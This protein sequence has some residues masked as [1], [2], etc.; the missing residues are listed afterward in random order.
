MSEFSC[1]V[2]VRSSA[3]YNYAAIAT[4]YPNA[5]YS[6]ISSTTD[7]YG[8]PWYKIYYSGSKTGYVCGYYAHT[9]TTSNDN[10]VITPNSAIN[11]RKG[12]ST[13]YSSIGTA[14]ANT[15]YS[16]IGCNC[17]DFAI[18]G[19]KWY[20]CMDSNG[21]V[22]WFKSSVVA[23]VKLKTNVTTCD[24][25]AGDYVSATYHFTGAS[26]ARKSPT[27]SAA[28]IRSTSFN[29]KCNVYVS[30]IVLNTSKELWYSVTITENGKSYNG[31][32]LGT[33]LK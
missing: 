23:G 10:Y 17:E 16:I 30:G 13:N 26:Y 20:Q 1:G 2:S 15:Y 19:T 9:V 3:N 4:I 8:R 25:N 21:K 11:M 33:L 32:V 31:Y 6:Y 27:T 22:F 5:A 12:P 24:I 29:T 28:K 18:T 7:S 14:K